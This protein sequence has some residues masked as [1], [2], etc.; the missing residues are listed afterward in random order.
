MKSH[1]TAGL[2]LVALL[3]L[4]G[5][6]THP[7]YGDVRVHDHDYDVRVVFSD[8]DR[9]IIREYYHVDYRRLPPGLA[10]QD[11]VPPGHAH[12]LRR[13]QPV[14]PGLEW[15]YL[16]GEVERRLSRLPDGYVRITIGGDVAILH[17]RTRVILDVIDTL[18]D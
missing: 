10:K 7:Y 8:D 6:E 2:V 17:T 15:R 3:G 13:H 1:M 4:A 16:P 9:R 11:K 18:D 12:R 5:C 14:P